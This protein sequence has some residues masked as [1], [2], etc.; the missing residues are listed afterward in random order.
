MSATFALKSAFCKRCVVR[1]IFYLTPGFQVNGSNG[2]INNTN[3][4]ESWRFCIATM[5]CLCM[6]HKYC[7][8][9]THFS[10]THF[11]APVPNYELGSVTFAAS[12]NTKFYTAPI[13]PSS[14]M[15][16]GYYAMGEQKDHNNFSYVLTHK[17]VGGTENKC[18]CWKKNHNILP[19]RVMLFRDI[20]QLAN[21]SVAWYFSGAL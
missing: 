3:K 9:D 18:T 8:Q 7:L 1:F 15:K 19:I 17:A 2:S 13:R 20:L 12:S 11:N 4:T 16:I 21:A 14:C 10:T 6:S 5:L